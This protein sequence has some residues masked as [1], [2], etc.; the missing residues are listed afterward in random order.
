MKKVTYIAGQYSQLKLDEGS[1]IFLETLPKKIRIKKMFLGII[2]TKTIWEFKFPFYIRT[3]GEAWD[4]AKEVLDIV[5]ESIKDSNGI[6]ELEQKLKSE[7]TLLLN[8]YI[9]NNEARAYQIGIEKLGSFAAKKYIQSS[10]IL[11]D[12]MAI[13]SDIMDIIG[14]Y[15]KVLE[16]LPKEGDNN[17]FHPISKLPHSKEKIENAL[18][19]ALKIAKDGQMIK[20]LKLVLAALKT[21]IPDDEVQKANQNFI[22]GLSKTFE[23]ESK[24]K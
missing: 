7:T 14:D 12:T 6:K 3:V 21:F 10:P 17:F 2:P 15:G 8:T 4:I 5:L 23:Q 13:P 11:K 19:T 18:N 22:K 20:H 1:R 9:D 16:D 24:E